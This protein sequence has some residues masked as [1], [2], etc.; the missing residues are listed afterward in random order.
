M[1]PRFVG[2]TI[3]L[4]NFIESFHSNQS[5]CYPVVDTRPRMIRCQMFVHSLD[6]VNNTDSVW[7]DTTVKQKRRPVSAV[8]MVAASVLASVEKPPPAASNQHKRR[9]S[10]QCAASSWQVCFGGG[11]MRELAI[12]TAFRTNASY[13]CN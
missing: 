9:R 8:A 11:Y 12:V 2:P 5:A 1:K 3:P 7:W 6:A 10:M 4:N 13:F